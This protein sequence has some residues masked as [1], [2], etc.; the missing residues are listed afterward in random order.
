VQFNHTW[1]EGNRSADWFAN[2]IFSLN[3]FDIHVMET[4]PGEVL[5]LLFYD[6][7]GLVCL[8]IFI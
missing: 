2:F 3:S 6:I 8:G 5:S 7:S 1:R 4:P